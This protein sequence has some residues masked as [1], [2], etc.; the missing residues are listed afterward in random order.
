MDFDQYI[1]SVIAEQDQADQAAKEEPAEEEVETKEEDEKEVN[2]DE[3][4]PKEKRSESLLSD[5]SNEEDIESEEPEVVSKPEKRKIPVKVY[6]KEKELELDDDEIQ[7]Y[8]QKGHAVDLQFKKNAE[9]RKELEEMR[10]QIDEIFSFIKKD[11]IGF[12]EKV[13]GQEKAKQL[14][15]ER[16]VESLALEK[17]SPEQRDAYLYERKIQERKDAAAREL[18]EIEAKEAD[19][20]NRY[21]VSQL[22]EM[23]QDALKSVD[24]PVT[25]SVH[26]EFLAFSMPYIRHNDDVTYEELEILADRFKE[27]KQETVRGTFEKL[28][29]EGLYNLLGKD[30]AEKLRKFFLKQA[31]PIKEV[32]AQKGSAPKSKKDP[33]KWDQRQTRDYFDSL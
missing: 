28:D 9:E 32:V 26:T 23:T 20:R 11:P 10:S 25:K 33:E 22:N 12:F 8:V 15:E 1:N 3:P 21:Y 29:G 5:A 24:L 16:V 17:M 27:V 7:K 30:N 18:A 13:V 4:Q 31:Q 2:E 6:G 19:E 14:Y